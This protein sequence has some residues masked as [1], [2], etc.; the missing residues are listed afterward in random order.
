VLGLA[1]KGKLQKFQSKKGAKGFVI[2]CDSYENC[3]VG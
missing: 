2:D 3:R 1:A